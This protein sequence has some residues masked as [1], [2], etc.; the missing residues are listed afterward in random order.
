[1]KN[2]AWWPVVSS[3]RLKFHAYK[4]RVLEQV[5]SKDP[6]A[7]K[8]VS[9]LLKLHEENQLS[10]MA[11]YEIFSLFQLEFLLSRFYVT[12]GTDAIW[13][14]NLGLIDLQAHGALQWNGF[15]TQEISA[16]LEDVSTL[17]DE[18]M[19]MIPAEIAIAFMTFQLLLA[20]AYLLLLTALS[21]VLPIPRG[22]INPI[23]K[24]KDCVSPHP[25]QSSW[26]MSSLLWQMKSVGSAVQ[27]GT[28]F[29]S[30][31]T[32]SPPI[33]WLLPTASQSLRLEKFHYVIILPFPFPLP[34]S[35]KVP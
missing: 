24:I 8:A 5:I 12:M 9:V 35:N 13:L 10:G 14:Y 32:V 17:W 23:Y 21:L 26:C 30:I 4:M 20:L 11:T 18:I 2:L 3:L 34:I 16:T 6:T 27:N 33:P 25:F 1:M 31:Y 22:S 29:V 15:S 7:P 28:H 19:F